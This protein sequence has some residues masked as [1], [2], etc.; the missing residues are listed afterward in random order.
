MQT[1]LKLAIVGAALGS[2]PACQTVTVNGYEITRSDQVALTVGAVVAGGIILSA[3]DGKE[4]E[5][6]V[7]NPG[8]VEC[9]ID[10]STGQCR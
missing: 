2:M 1:T 4:A 7:S 6:E 5:P 9:V 10:L 3:A 8:F